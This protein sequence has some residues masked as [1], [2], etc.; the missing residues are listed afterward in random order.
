MGSEGVHLGQ[1]GRVQDVHARSN[2]SNGIFGASDALV[3]HCHVSRNGGS[4][5]V[6]I[7]NSVVTDNVVE[8]SGG[9]Q[10]GLVG[11]GI[12][13]GN[14]VSAGAAD[15]I[16]GSGTLIENNES[17]FNIGNGITVGDGSRVV[18]NV[19]QFNL[20]LAINFTGS[21]SG[22]ADNVLQAGHPPPLVGGIVG[23]I[24]LGG[25]LCN[26]AICP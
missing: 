14:S 8:L 12:I 1:A 25:N 18:G 4:G 2:G 21:Q 13:R 9:T 20:L 22:Y 26:G 7:G 15:G 16:S 10:P 6:A 3:I 11:G 5:I 24:N 17:S 19:V 23:N